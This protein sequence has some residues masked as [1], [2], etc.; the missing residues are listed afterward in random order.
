MVGRISDNCLIGG[1][2]MILEQKKV[3]YIL[4]Y[5][6]VFL[7]ILFNLK[8]A[9]E[10]LYFMKMKNTNSL[11]GIAIAIIVIHHL[12]LRVKN[13]GLLIS[14]RGFGYIS[15]SIFLFLSGY[16]LTM[17]YLNKNNY[18]DKFISKR[19]T[20][21]YLP[22]VFVNI[23]N[24]I[25]NSLLGKYT[26]SVQD[27]IFFIAGIKL[28]NG[29]MW[30]IITTL[31]WYTCFY[32]IFT[33]MKRRYI[34]IS[35]F[36]VGVLYFIVCYK[37]N[38]SK[39]WYDTSLTFPFGVMF[40]FRKDKIIELSRRYYSYLVVGATILFSILFIFNYG[41][42]TLSAICIRALASVAFVILVNLVFLKLDM[43]KNNIAMFLGSISFEIYLIHDRIIDSG[44][45][46]RDIN[47]VHI[48]GYFIIVI[49]LAILLEKLINILNIVVN[50]II[51]KFGQA[52]LTKGPD[53]APSKERNV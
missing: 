39:N 24:I 5:G 51:S 52:A 53:R 2:L 49:I 11:K 46:G 32:L 27:F 26:Y 42:I 20:R 14:F 12:I 41:K 1:D 44:L 28:L 23:V 10:K 35:M 9:K 21:V 40:C 33:Y 29:T 45:L 18:L 16:G 34:E 31:F 30:Y 36:I 13:P 19:L 47:V 4:I 3:A 38:L 8:M 22:F 25:A 17:S 7:C 6:I 37:L 48:A 15:V 43:S 50:K